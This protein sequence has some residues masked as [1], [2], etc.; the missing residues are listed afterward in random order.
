LLP[1]CLCISPVITFEFPPFLPAVEYYCG[2]YR[3]DGGDDPKKATAR[4]AGLTYFTG[5]IKGVGKGSIVF[6]GGGLWDPA[7]GAVCDWETDPD[8]GTGALAGLKAKGHHVGTPTCEG[9][10][11]TV[12]I[13]D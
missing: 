4:F 2:N 8:S 10:P 3:N 1:S 5:E 13:Q 6:L 11:V 7:K 9:D 12:E